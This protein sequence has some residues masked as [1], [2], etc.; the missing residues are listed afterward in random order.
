MNNQLQKYIKDNYISKK[1]IEDKIKE[2]ENEYKAY[3]TEYDLP[4]EKLEK[5]LQLIK[6]QINILKLILQENMEEENYNHI[7]RI[8]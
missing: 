7:P 4:K 6:F 3:K 1:V 2:L 5:D 8:D